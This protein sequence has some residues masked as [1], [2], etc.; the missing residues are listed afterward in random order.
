MRLHWEVAWAFEVLLGV[1]NFNSKSN[2][3]LLFKE[4]TPGHTSS[5]LNNWWN[6]QENL[7]RWLV[8]HKLLKKML[9]FY[10][11][12]NP[13]LRKRLGSEKLFLI[14]LVSKFKTTER[15]LSL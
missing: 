3:M 15:N 10:I 6:Q 1:L 4:L 13:I 7:V 14:L 11:E 9:F 12:K 5:Q 2:R 8:M